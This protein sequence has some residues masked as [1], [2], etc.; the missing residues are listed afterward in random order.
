MGEVI[1]YI[2]FAII[3]YILGGTFGLA[4][5]SGWSPDCWY[6]MLAVFGIIVIGGECGG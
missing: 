5:G 4:F 1:G 2:V 6:G 3:G